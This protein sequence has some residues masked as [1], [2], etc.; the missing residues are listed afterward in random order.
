MVELLA[1][2]HDVK[3]TAFIFAVELWRRMA[4][5]NGYIPEQEQDVKEAPNAFSVEAERYMA[6]PC[7]PYSLYPPAEQAVK[8]TSS[9]LS[10][11]PPVKWKH[12]PYDEAL[13]LEKARPVNVTSDPSSM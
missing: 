1:V 3:E 10:V 9:T 8:S 6:P 5:A 13:P 4:P 2:P 7:G 12:P 11:L